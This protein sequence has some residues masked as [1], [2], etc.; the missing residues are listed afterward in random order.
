MLSSQQVMQKTANM[1]QNLQSQGCDIVVKDDKKYI[2]IPWVGTAYRILDGAVT[3]FCHEPLISIGE[4]PSSREYIVLNPDSPILKSHYDV[5]IA[6]CSQESE[7][8]LLQAVINVVKSVFSS[9]AVERVTQ[10]WKGLRYLSSPVISLA[11]FIYKNPGVGMCRHH[12]LFA[13]YLLS[14]LIQEG[15]LKGKVYHA[16]GYVNNGAHVWVVYKPDQLDDA[17][18]IDTVWNN[19]AFLLK[20]NK[21]KLL[22]YN[23]C[24][25]QCVIRYLIKYKQ[26]N[27]PGT[28]FFFDTSKGECQFYKDQ[29]A[30]QN[31]SSAATHIKAKLLG[32]GSYGLVSLMNPVSSSVNYPIA[33]KEFYCGTK[34]SIDTSDEVI[35]QVVISRLENFVQEVRYNYELNGIGAV[36]CTEDPVVIA[37]EEEKKI[38][39]NYPHAVLAMEYVEGSPL[40]D[41]KI[42]SAKTY[43][44]IVLATLVALSKLHTKFIHGDIH[45]YN[46]IVSDDKK[47][48]LTARFVD[49][50]LSRHRGEMITG[51]EDLNLQI[52]APEFKNKHSIEAN[53]SQDIWCAGQM[54]T[55]LVKSEWFSPSDYSEV[56]KILQ[57]M[58]AEIPE[59]RSSLESSICS[60]LLK[61]IQMFSEECIMSSLEVLSSA[62]IVSVVNSIISSADKIHLFFT[63]NNLKRIQAKIS[64]EDY[65]KLITLLIS[66]KLGLLRGQFDE[67]KSKEVEHAILFDKILYCERFIRELSEKAL[68]SIERA[69]SGFDKVNQDSSWQVGH[70]AER[71]KEYYIKSDLSNLIE[72]LK[73]HAPVNKLVLLESLGKEYLIT[74]LIDN[75]DKFFSVFSVIPD[76]QKKEFLL[77]MSYDYLTSLHFEIYGYAKLIPYLEHI[78]FF[79]FLQ[80]NPNNLGMSLKLISDKKAFLHALFKAY[81]CQFELEFQPQE[82]GDPVHPISLDKAFY[83][84]RY[85]DEISNNNANIIIRAKKGFKALS[86]PW[87]LGHGIERFKEKCLMGKLENL[88]VKLKERVNELQLELLE[89]LGKDYVFDTFIKSKADVLSV[90]SVIHKDNKRDFIRFIGW[91]HLNWLTHTEMHTYQLIAYAAELF[92][93]E[94]ALDFLR[95]A[96]FKFETARQLIVELPIDVHKSGLLHQLGVIQQARS[97]GGRERYSVFRVAVDM[98]SPVS[99]QPANQDNHRSP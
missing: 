29:P 20:K 12:A 13:A 70:G 4:S 77:V 62:N 56:E 72:R 57:A 43:C 50:T 68:G 35:K 65:Y 38:V 33:V 36:F 8:R 27:P 64:Q 51:L 63:V 52:K 7:S 74:K 18:L 73:Q 23:Q 94:L 91:V 89:C 88:I 15:L 17:Y 22:A 21:D 3:D 81:K 47:G 90:L 19:E 76:V 92:N 53:E 93:N 86:A 80:I 46:V 16:R 14:K 1:M 30:T 31:N 84:E 37:I 42:D 40:A 67:K 69:T 83:C 5:M 39:K 26:T 24:I 32:N 10:D 41:Y 54:L 28:S 82:M 44:Q 58:M 59:N 78:T 71:F 9:T 34:F 45:E 75:R 66:Y 11:E 87:K 2:S 85:L 61:F 60:L 99:L 48:H 98:A 96:N 6:S 95:Q 55:T 79:D 49:F 97:Q 25:D